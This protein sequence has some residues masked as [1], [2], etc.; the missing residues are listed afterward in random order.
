MK[1]VLKPLAK[2]VLISIGIPAAAA[3]TYAAINKNMVGS[4]FRPSDLA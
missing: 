3:T 1:N 4:M 2:R